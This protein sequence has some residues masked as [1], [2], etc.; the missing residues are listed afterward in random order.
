ML[1][2]HNIDTSC[3]DPTKKSVMF[4]YAIIETGGEQLRVEPGRFYDVSRFTP[5]KPN[6][7]GPNAKVS[8]YQVLMICHESMINIGHPWL[9]G[10]VVKGPILHS[11][12]GD[13]TIIYKMRPKKKTQHKSVHRHNS[14]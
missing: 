6:L 2:K 10:V 14:A 9:T 3:N 13:K 5:S 12:L 7:L 4:T 1:S 8:S 11:C